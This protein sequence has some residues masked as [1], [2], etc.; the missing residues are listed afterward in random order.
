MMIADA[1][2]KRRLIENELWRV[3]QPIWGWHEAR[4]IKVLLAKPHL[5]HPVIA[6]ARV[7]LFALAVGQSST[8]LWKRSIRMR[9][10][11]IEMADYPL[12]CSTV[13]QAW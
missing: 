6:M 1:L 8:L 4:I 9:S 13:L 11:A 12:I 10:I 2:R 3:R 7:K 5:D